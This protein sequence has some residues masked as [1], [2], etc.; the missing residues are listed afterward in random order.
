MVTLTS[1]GLRSLSALVA[2]HGFTRHIETARKNRRV[3][4]TPV[5]EPT[6]S[7]SSPN[8]G[9]IAQVRF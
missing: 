8:V 6:G 2:A 5:V 3:V 9:F 7:T 4:V 1:I